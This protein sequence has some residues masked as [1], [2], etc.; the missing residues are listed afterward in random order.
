MSGHQRPSLSEE[1]MWTI[2]Q[3]GLA[4]SVYNIESA[5]WLRGELNVTAVRD[6]FTRLVVRHPALRTRFPEGPQ[7]PVRLVEEPGADGS[8]RVDFEVI[9]VGREEAVTRAGESAAAPFDLLTGPLM[10]V[11]VF[12]VNAGEHL[13][14]VTVHHMVFDGWSEGI[15]LQ[16]FAQVYSALAE[17][18]E[19]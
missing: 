12:R 1:W 7:G 16:E 11:R 6:A 2:E 10:R 5:L 8:V 15:L 3:S 4:T 14:V 18:R 9:E 13:L 17:G 19:P